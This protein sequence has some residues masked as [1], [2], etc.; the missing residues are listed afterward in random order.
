MILNGITPALATQQYGYQGKSTVGAT[1]DLIDTIHE[2]F[3]TNQYVI[4]LY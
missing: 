4:Y 3:E 1:T 2:A